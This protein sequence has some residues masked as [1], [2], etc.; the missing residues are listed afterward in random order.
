[1]QQSLQLAVDQPSDGLFDVGLAIAADKSHFIL[2]GAVQQALYAAGNPIQRV[3]ER[4]FL[5]S[6]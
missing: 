3:R 1:M 5:G 2:F 4:R 6:S